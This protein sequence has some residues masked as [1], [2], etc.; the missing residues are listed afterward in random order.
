M[1]I[2]NGGNGM[3]VVS[4]ATMERLKLP[5]KPHLKSYKVAWINSTSILVIEQCLVSISRA[6]YN[7]SIWCDIIAMTVMQ[8][9]LGRP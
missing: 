7:D 8:I 9:L 5:T 4:K 2:I 1:L 3:N 6:Q